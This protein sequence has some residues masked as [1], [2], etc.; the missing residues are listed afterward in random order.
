MICRLRL[1]NQFRACRQLVLL[2]RVHEQDDF[3]KSLERKLA[4][5]EADLKTENIRCSA[6]ALM[7]ISTCVAHG[8]F[9]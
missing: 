2:L 1:L 6:L 8:I 5:V 9:T 4:E 3:I 7:I